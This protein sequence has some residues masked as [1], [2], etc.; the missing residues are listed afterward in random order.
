[1]TCLLLKKRGTDRAGREEGKREGREKGWERGKEGDSEYCFRN[2]QMSKSKMPKSFTCGA[3][4]LHIAH[5][6]TEYTLNHC[7][8]CAVPNALQ[9]VYK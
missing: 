1:M 9:M 3:Q 4:Y 8:L 2:L 6:P 7:K 5:V